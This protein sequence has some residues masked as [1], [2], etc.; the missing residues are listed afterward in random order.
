MHKKLFSIAEFKKKTEHF[1][2]HIKPYFALRSSLQR[3]PTQKPS[4][5]LVRKP[6]LGPITLTCRRHCRHHPPIKWRQHGPESQPTPHSIPHTQLT[7]DQHSPSERLEVPRLLLPSEGVNLVGVGY[8]DQL[9]EFQ[10]TGA[11][12]APLLGCCT[13]TRRLLAA[14]EQ[15][16]VRTNYTLQSVSKQQFPQQL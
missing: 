16:L 15:P 1:S 6:A 14:I 10:S 5:Q 13:R 8:V 11:R 12:I 9:A 7:T 4:S 2:D 3:V